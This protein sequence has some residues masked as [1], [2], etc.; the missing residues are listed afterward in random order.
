IDLNGNGDF[1]VGIRSALVKANKAK[2]FA[3]CGIVQ[4]SKPEEEFY[5]TGVKFLPMLNALGGLRN[6]RE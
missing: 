2:L 4:D 5:E 6:E 3:G 1:A